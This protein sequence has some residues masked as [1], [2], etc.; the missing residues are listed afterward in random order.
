MS[1]PRNITC[2]RCGAS[3]RI[4]LFWIAGIEGIFRCKSCRLP[5]KTGYRMGALLFALAFSLSVVTV[6]LLVWIFSAYSL[7]FFILLL[8]PLWIVY[9]FIFRRRYM[10]WRLRRKLRKKEFI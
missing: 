9:G 2:P 3:V 10:L 1:S 5:F 7:W 4:P 6:Q 8:V